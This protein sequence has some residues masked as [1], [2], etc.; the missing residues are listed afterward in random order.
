MYGFCNS[1]FGLLIIGSDDIGICYC[2]F[3]DNQTEALDLMK[4]RLNCAAI[5]EKEHKSHHIISKFFSNDTDSSIHTVLHL[6]CTDFQYAVW[7]ALLE[8]PKGTTTTYRQIAEKTGSPHA[9]RA[10]GT[11]VGQNPVALLIPCHRVILS[12][13][14]IGQYRWGAKRK[15]NILMREK[16]NC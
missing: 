15:E 3:A 6:K 5:I 8:I 7:S 9:W 1:P 10:T 14:R 11:A 16:Q 13:G 12:D 2:A 4:K